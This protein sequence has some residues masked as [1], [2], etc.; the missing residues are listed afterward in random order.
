MDTHQNR[1]PR[2]LQ[3]RDPYCI[4]RN[5]ASRSVS[6]TRPFPAGFSF[7]TPEP[8]PSYRAFLGGC[9]LT[10][11][12]SSG[13]ASPVNNLGPPS[14]S[15][16]LFRPMTKRSKAHKDYQDAVLEADAERR[17]QAYWL[18]YCDLGIE[19][20]VECWD[21]HVDYCLA[22]SDLAAEKMARLN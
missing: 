13:S 11:S 22:L 15:G 16:L 1:C 12:P 3:T 17:D 7:S 10:L 20:P 18:A 6:T 14:T 8:S 19:P 4:F 9:A 5:I 2:P 21:A